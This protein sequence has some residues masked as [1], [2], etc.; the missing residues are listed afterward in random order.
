MRIRG[1][2]IN[3]PRAR[4]EKL[5]HSW[6]M[7]DYEDLWRNLQRGAQPLELG[8][9]RYK[10]TSEWE[11]NRISILFDRNRIGMR[12]STCVYRR[13]TRVEET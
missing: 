10:I 1:D 6:S 4:V 13:R 7:C 9:W 11:R 12:Q 8:R 2:S 3:G 5:D